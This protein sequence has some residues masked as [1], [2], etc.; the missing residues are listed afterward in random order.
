MVAKEDGLQKSDTVVVSGAMV[1]V[2][3]VNL[4]S[5]E[6]ELHRSLLHPQVGS[7]NNST[8]NLLARF[9]LGSR[10]SISKVEGRVPKRERY[11]ARASSPRVAASHSKAA[12]N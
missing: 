5:Y 2:R 12:V 10:R 8:N 3:A 4:V 1:D 11:V 6:M 7:K 9:A